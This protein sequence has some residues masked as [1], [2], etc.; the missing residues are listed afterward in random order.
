MTRYP[1]YEALVERYGGLPAQQDICGC[2]VHVD[3][4]DLDTAVA[5]M[6]RARPY[7]CVLLALTGSSPFHEGVDTGYESFRT[8]WFAR[9]PIAGPPEPFGTAARY[10]EVVD[11][12]AAAGALNDASNLYW[13]VRPSARYPTLEFR[14]GDVCTDLDDAVL[15]AALARSLVRVLADRAARDEPFPDP[16]PELLRAARW[17][18]ARDGIRGQLFDPVAA[19]LVDARL[20]VRRLL[21]EL[22]DDLCE[23]GE[24]DEVLELVRR[25]LRRGT[26]AGRQRAV[27][28]R[29]GD[30]R[31]VA[32][33]VL[34]DSGC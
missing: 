30:G 5:V 19:C 21:A 14:V 24:W 23:H 10:R 7:L 16:R 31:E 4:A 15:H 27:W 18:A 2:H 6:D 34:R 22:E 33:A 9:W 11:G 1:R 8:L 26:S 29:T 32:A 3:V 17:R 12:L 13:D 20:A 25:V 28:N